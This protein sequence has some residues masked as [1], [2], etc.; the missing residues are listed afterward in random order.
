M[1]VNKNKIGCT[2]DT[3]SCA[4]WFL[5][6]RVRARECFHH[7]TLA[8]KMKNRA[9]MHRPSFEFTIETG[10][11]VSESHPSKGRPKRDNVARGDGND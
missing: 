10:Q 9:L 1:V 6:V 4:V 3:A 5:T 7:N 2:I 11:P 8:G